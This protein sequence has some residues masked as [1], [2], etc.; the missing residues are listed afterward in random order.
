MPATSSVPR[1]AITRTCRPSEADTVTTMGRSA[2]GELGAGGELAHNRRRVEYHVNMAAQNNPQM[3]VQHEGGRYPYLYETPKPPRGMT[4][5][6]LLYGQ[7]IRH[8]PHS[9]QFS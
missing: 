9:I 2:R 4:H 1:R 6:M 5:E 8:A 7:I 3:S